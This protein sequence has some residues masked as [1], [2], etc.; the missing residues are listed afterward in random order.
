[1][2][3]TSTVTAQ[4]ILREHEIVRALLNDVCALLDQGHEQHDNPEWNWRLCDKLWQFRRHL[5]RHFVLEETGGFLEDVVLRW[6]PAEEQVKKL[7]QDHVR[8]L[9][10]VDDLINASDLQASGWGTSFADFRQRCQSLLALIQ[11]HETE[12]NELIQ[13]VYYLEISALD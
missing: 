2:N 12:E 3:E 6:P 9:R 8:I 7:R 4:E 13:K 11:R 1:M 5:L 10:G